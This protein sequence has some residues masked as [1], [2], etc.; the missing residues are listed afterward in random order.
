MDNEIT[1]RP[2]VKETPFLAF[3]VEGILYAWGVL[4]EY[5]SL[6][7]VKDLSP[8]PISADLLSLSGLGK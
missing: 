2:L 1:C 4:T 7:V 8:Q 3:I 6:R 5:L